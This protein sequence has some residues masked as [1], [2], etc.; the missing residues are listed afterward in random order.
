MKSFTFLILFIFLILLSN[1]K[2]DW[3]DTEMVKQAVAIFIPIF[4][5]ILTAVFLRITYP[6]YKRIKFLRPYFAVILIVGFG[7]AAFYFQ[8]DELK[9]LKQTD[10][11]PRMI[12]DAYENIS[13]EYFSFSYAVVNIYATNSISK[14]QHFFINYEDFLNEYLEKDFLFHKNLKNKKFF[15]E[16]PDNVLPKSVFVFVYKKNDGFVSPLVDEG[17]Q[18]KEKLESIIKTLKK[19]GRKIQ[20]IYTNEVFEVQEIINKPNELKLNDLIFKI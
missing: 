17:L 11:T 7:Y 8:E 16:N 19:R 1:V 13:S 10:K 9:K 15:L 5:G 18:H 6:V 12:L 3:I 4:I 2:N 20:T 14:N